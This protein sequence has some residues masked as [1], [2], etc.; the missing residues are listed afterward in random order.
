M[1]KDF[2]G[3]K[4]G[5]LLKYVDFFTEGKTPNFIDSNKD[6]TKKKP[7]K[8]GKNKLD[9]KGKPLQKGK[10]A[11]KG[12]IPPQLAKFIKKRG[13]KNGKEKNNN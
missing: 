1:K 2:K 8:K 5:E 6:V 10:S 13:G 9:Q 11:R 7:V 12:K 3:R 4:F